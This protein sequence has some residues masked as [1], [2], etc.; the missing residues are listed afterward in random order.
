MSCALS[1]VMGN[2]GKLVTVEAD[3]DVWAMHQ[4][5]SAGSSL[6]YMNHLSSSQAAIVEWLKF[7]GESEEAAINVSPKILYCNTRLHRG[8]S[9]EMRIWQVPA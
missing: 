6:T 8:F 1:E 4:V 7:S 5:D 9:A 3:P 2:N